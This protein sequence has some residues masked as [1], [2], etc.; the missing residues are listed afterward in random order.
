MA[1][2]RGLRF[3]A[4]LGKTPKESRILLLEVAQVSHQFTAGLLPPAAQA[5]THTRH[6]LQDGVKCSHTGGDAWCF[7]TAESGAAA[8]GDDSEEGAPTGPQKCN[9]WDRKG[10]NPAMNV[11]VHL[12]SSTGDTDSSGPGGSSGE[13][14]GGGEEAAEEGPVR[15]KLGVLVQHAL[16]KLAGQVGGYAGLGLDW[17]TWTAEGSGGAPRIATVA[18]VG[19]QDD[20]HWGR[21]R[22]LVRAPCLA[23]CCR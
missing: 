9:A 20:E 11:Y 10:R 14:G 1:L 12:G 3:T 8:A 13:G 22:Q 6:A 19:E 16:P 18:G 23:L 17:V 7:V 15:C 21:L 2:K 5:L 4:S